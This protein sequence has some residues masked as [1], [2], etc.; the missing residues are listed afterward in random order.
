MNPVITV[1]KTNPIIIFMTL[2]TML[3]SL[4]LHIKTILIISYAIALIL[5]FFSP[6]NFLLLAYDTIGVTTGAVSVPFIMAFGLGIALML[7]W[8]EPVTDSVR[9]TVL[10]VGQGQCLILQSGN[11]RRMAMPQADNADA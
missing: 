1:N 5:G 11:E 4:Y 8:L 9:M 3:I 10:D 2:N 6:L 7:S